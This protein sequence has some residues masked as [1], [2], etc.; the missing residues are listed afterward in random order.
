L[1]IAKTT[2]NVSTCINLIKDHETTFVVQ[3]L[4]YWSQEWWMLDS[5]KGYH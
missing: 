2:L 1:T 3:L 5:I 4:T